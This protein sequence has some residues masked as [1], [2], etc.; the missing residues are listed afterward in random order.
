MNKSFKRIMR[1]VMLFCMGINTSV[2]FLGLSLGQFDIY[3]L[4]GISGVLCLV[5]YLNLAQDEAK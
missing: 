5:G 2:F 3:T 1:P 4:S